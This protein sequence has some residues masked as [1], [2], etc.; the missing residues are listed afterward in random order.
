MSHQLEDIAPDGAY[1]KNLPFAS[2]KKK[3]FDTGWYKI[4]Q[5]FYTHCSTLLQR[6]FLTKSS[7][8]DNFYSLAYKQTLL[9]S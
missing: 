7:K 3:S 4:E 5:N 2:I 9:R 6:I 1:L 8:T